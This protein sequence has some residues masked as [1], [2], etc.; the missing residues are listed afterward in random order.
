MKIAIDLG[1]TTVVFALFSPDHSICSTVTCR[2]LQA[3]FGKDVISRIKASQEGC[4]QELWEK[5]A[6][7]LQEGLSLL[8][9]E[10]QAAHTLLPIQQIIIAA[11]TTMVH[12]LMRYDCQGLGTYPFTSSHLDGTFAKASSIL[13]QRNSLSPWLSADCPVRILPGI[14]AFVGGDLTGGILHAGLDSS[15][16]ISL[17]L[18]LGTNAEMLLGTKDRML[19]AS[20]AAGPAFEGMGT[21][22]GSEVLHGIAQ[23]LRSQRIDSTGLL[24]KP[25]FH[26]GYPYTTQSGRRIL[27]RQKDVR[28]IQVAKAAVRA[29]ILLLCREYG[30]QEDDIQTLYLAGSLG[31]A[32]DPQDAWTLGLLPPNVPIRTLGNSSLYGAVH[33]DSYSTE[34]ILDIRE[35]IMQISLADLDGFNQCFV[36]QMN[37][38]ITNDSID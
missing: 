28:R 37:F 1:T 7:T 35:N 20:A 4:G 3:A 31:Y 33:A 16:Q 12:L 26:S 5:V 6:E 38:P 2:N 32:T 8:Y 34:R 18:D 11:N 9:R 10:A 15:D 23:M 14:S 36:E 29:G 27:F 17:L 13:L 19:A 21:T 24:K 22:Y 30:C 25:Y